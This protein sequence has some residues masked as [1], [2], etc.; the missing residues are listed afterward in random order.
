M[1]QP[2]LNRNGIRVLD[3]PRVIC[4]RKVAFFDPGRQGSPSQRRPTLAN[5][6]RTT[7]ALNCGSY[8]I[9]HQQRFRQP[10]TEM[11][12]KELYHV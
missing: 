1:T 3:A 2:R 7:A 11:S 5:P 12:Q 10:A 8:H 9:G 4:Q 6:S